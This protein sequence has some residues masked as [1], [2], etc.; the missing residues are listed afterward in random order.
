MSNL[1]FKTANAPSIIFRIKDLKITDRVVLFNLADLLKK[2]VEPTQKLLEYVTGI[3]ERT[4]NR[5]LKELEK[6]GFISRKTTLFNGKGKKTEYNIIWDKISKYAVA[7]DYKN[8]NIQENCQNVEN[9]INDIDD[10]GN[11]SGYAINNQRLEQVEETNYTPIGNY[12][13]DDD[14]SKFPSEEDFYTPV[15]NEEEQQYMG[16]KTEIPV[17]TD[18]VTDEEKYGS[19]IIDFIE[20]NPEVLTA[21]KAVVDYFEYNDEEKELG[22][23]GANN[24]INRLVKESGNANEDFVSRLEIYCADFCNDYKESINNRLNENEY[25]RYE[26]AS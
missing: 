15:W 23:K 12:N 5:S 25:D 9:N 19:D 3:S 14:L 6:L 13:D 4:L 17:E 2:N 10:M 24:E 26:F 21:L 1:K 18:F 20:E 16:D 11:F 8:G 7:N 22:A